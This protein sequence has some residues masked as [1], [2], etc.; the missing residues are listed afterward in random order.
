MK[1]NVSIGVFLALVMLSS[2]VLASY[3]IQQTVPD[4]TKEFDDTNDQLEWSTNGVNFREEARFTQTHT[5]SPAQDGSVYDTVISSSRIYTMANGEP[6]VLNQD[7]G[8]SGTAYTNLFPG[9]SLQTL[10]IE[11]GQS[12]IAKMSSEFE[13]YTHKKGEIDRYGGNYNLTF[14]GFSDQLFLPADLLATPFAYTQTVATGD[15]ST[16][17]DNNNPCSYQSNH[18]V[19]PLCEN[20]NCSTAAHDTTLRIANGD[21]SPGMTGWNIATSM[22]NEALIFELENEDLS[23]EQANLF[24]RASGEDEWTQMQNGDARTSNFIEYMIAPNETFYSNVHSMPHTIR[25]EL[26]IPILYNTTH[27]QEWLPT[28]IT[29]AAYMQEGR[30]YFSAIA[31]HETEYYRSVD[32]NEN[33]TTNMTADY[34]IWD[35]EVVYV[36]ENN[37]W[38]TDSKAQSMSWKQGVDRDG[39]HIYGY[40]APSAIELNGGVALVQ[41]PA[42]LITSAISPSINKDCGHWWSSGLGTPKCGSWDNFETGD[43]WCGESNSYGHA[44]CSVQ[45]FSGNGFGSHWNTDDTTALPLIDSTYDFDGTV[46][47]VGLDRDTWISQGS[48]GYDELHIEV[49]LQA[50]GYANSLSSSGGWSSGAGSW[51]SANG[52]WFENCFN[53]YIDLYAIPENDFDNWYGYAQYSFPWAPG[54]SNYAYSATD[55]SSTGAINWGIRPD[56][57]FWSPDEYWYE[58]IGSSNN[59]AL[60][61]MTEKD[62]DGYTDGPKAGGASHTYDLRNSD[63]WANMYSHY[64]GG[65]MNGPQMKVNNFQAHRLPDGYK[66]LND[67]HIEDGGGAYNGDRIPGYD[68]ILNRGEGIYESSFNHQADYWDINFYS[69]ADFPFGPQGLNDAS[70][71]TLQPDGSFGP[72]SAL[73]IYHLETA[74]LGTAEQDFCYDPVSTTG[75]ARS[76]NMIG[77]EQDSK[78]LLSHDSNDGQTYLNID[79]GSSPYD[80]ILAESATM[81]T[82]EL[83]AKGFLDDA[84]DEEVNFYILIDIRSRTAWNENTEWN[85]GEYRTEDEWYDEINSQLTFGS[86]VPEVQTPN[87]AVCWGDWSTSTDLFDTEDGHWWDYETGQFV[88]SSDKFTY[89]D[90]FCLDKY[91]NNFD[92]RAEVSFSEFI[93]TTTCVSDE[94]DSGQQI[95]QNPD[96]AFWCG[97]NLMSPENDDVE[98][99]RIIAQSAPYI[100]QTDSD[101]DGVLD[102]NDLCPD[103]PLNQEVDLD[104]CPIT[105][106][107]T[108]PDLED[109]QDENLPYT[110]GGDYDGDGVIDAVDMCDTR[111]GEGYQQDYAWYTAQMHAQFVASQATNNPMQVRWYDGCPVRNTDD[112][113]SDD[114][115]I[116]PDDDNCINTGDMGIYP[117]EDNDDDGFIDEDYIDGKDN[118]GDGLIDED[119]FDDCPDDDMDLYRDDNFNGI[120]E[121]IYSVRDVDGRYIPKSGDQL[122]AEQD[123]QIDDEYNVYHTTYEEFSSRLPDDPVSQS[124]TLLFHNDQESLASTQLM[125]NAIETNEPIRTKIQLFVWMP[126]TE[127]NR[128]IDSSA[129]LTESDLNLAIFGRASQTN[130]SDPGGSGV[131]GAYVPYGQATGFHDP[132]NPLPIGTTL[133]NYSGSALTQEGQLKL[134]SQ[135]DFVADDPIMFV[136]FAEGHYRFNCIGEQTK[137]LQN[138][139]Q[140]QANMVVSQDFVAVAPCPDG[141]LPNPPNLAGTCDRS[142]GGGSGITTSSTVNDL[143]DNI[144]L[145]G[146][147]ILLFAVAVLLWFID[148]KLASVGLGMIS[149]AFGLT[150]GEESELIGTIS[151]VLIAGGL[152]SLLG[153][154][155]DRLGIPL[156]RLYMP[157]SFV[158]FLWHSLA[159]FDVVSEPAFFVNAYSWAAV[160]LAILFGVITAAQILNVFDV[161]TPIDDI[162]AMIDLPNGLLAKADIAATREELGY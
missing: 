73:S 26:P 64:L 124:E 58:E 161:D 141:N 151:H 18:L 36:N 10:T 29:H 133:F 14:S 9:T 119:P 113:G 62:G 34:I 89:D 49:G 5:S 137:T 90:G 152:L 76:N 85:G 40:A 78:F 114:D 106:S 4:Y 116:T 28:T 142:S 162:P 101:G 107:P 42:T 103:T 13:Y 81:S 94:P 55:P 148:W 22:V 68:S 97:L 74:E 96:R 32:S 20:N 143:L 102:I 47:K 108:N 67:D 31:T 69:D 1:R 126:Y 131:M 83:V 118:D 117:Y 91:G 46:V 17:D 136:N 129:S 147:V 33:I 159:L 8:I 104:G 155:N 99:I 38:S 98:P 79:I 154:L 23:N 51:I 140:Y 50:M 84:S 24:I 70:V 71:G 15:T 120:I 144:M 59:N 125:C 61:A 86:S 57:D 6:A 44:G 150:A 45:G 111:N 158:W 93:D 157:I 128:V 121:A 145:L 87:M 52:G 12:N 27:E 95:G 138:G 19:L 66:L 127:I 60:V 139:Q 112:G 115:L 110:G 92:S 109:D 63:Y 156:I 88:Q 146:I 25:G 7:M 160:S 56:N 134:S 48:W 80:N 39:A 82:T 105:E 123:N 16:C 100:P 53:G 132:F 2:T 37:V 43:G 75:T 135:T 3:T 77:V 122:V 149:I 54:N 35:P 30:A 130:Y 72:T 41:S 11:G 65:Y 153:S 21:Y